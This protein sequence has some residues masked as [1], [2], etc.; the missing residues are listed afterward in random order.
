MRRGWN[1]GNTLD[2]TSGQQVREEW[3]FASLKQQGFDWVRIP[4]CWGPRAGNWAPYTVESWF[5]DQVKETVGWALKYGLTVLLN[6]HHEDWLDDNYWS[7]AERF[8]AIWSQIAQAFSSYSTAT[9]VFELMNEPLH[10]SVDA[11]NDL[12]AKVLPVVRA[13]SPS[14]LVYLGG[15]RQMHPTWILEN[16]N[17]MTIPND[18]H[19][20]VT[21][22][23]C[24]GTETRTPS[25][26]LL[27]MFPFGPH[28]ALPPPRETE[29]HF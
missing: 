8:K 22:H 28:A 12:N 11:L 10:M 17:A 21:F 4:V 13:V 18:K 9:L 24:R 26:H 2:F 3:I 1:L 27:S 5:M 20:G 16:P 14:R 15:L 7:N 23:M 29:A 19:L 6:A 25:P